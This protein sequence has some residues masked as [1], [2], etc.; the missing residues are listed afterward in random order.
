MHPRR[1]LMPLALAAVI[2][3]T[4]VGSANSTSRSP[5]PGAIAPGADV[6]ATATVRSTG[7][8]SVTRLVVRDLKTGAL[9]V[10]RTVP[11]AWAL[12]RPVP[13]GAPEGLSW[14]GSTAVL[15]SRTST[16]RFAVIK[17]KAQ[18]PPRI[19]E[20]RASGALEY[21]ALSRSGS[22]L[23]LSEYADKEAETLDRIRV[24]DVASGR[25][26]AR[27]VVDKS[28]S[29]AMA[30]VPVIRVVSRDG[31]TT[32]TL[33]EGPSHPFVHLLMTDSAISICI[34]LP[35]VGSPSRAGRWT[36]RLDDGGRR[37]R[38]TSSRLRKQFLVDVGQQ[39]GTVT[40]ANL[41]G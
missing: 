13:G 27:A 16:D 39:L 5:L 3:L 2:S 17:L 21:D 34:D 35:A 6:A 31:R 25:M 11:G 36:L 23:Y 9:R 29:T 33:Y 12:P 40:V 28:G 38:A 7:G 32:Y 26:R 41:P 15:R 24:V 37:L 14:D 19:L 8:S 18:S 4:A 1:W 20:L 22:K 10:V 30:G